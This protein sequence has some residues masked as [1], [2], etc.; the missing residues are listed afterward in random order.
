MEG[1]GNGVF[2]VTV[3]VDDQRAG[4]TIVRTSPRTFAFQNEK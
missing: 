4:S 3:Q 2:H 1:A